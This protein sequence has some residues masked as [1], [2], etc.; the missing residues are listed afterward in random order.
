[1]RAFRPAGKPGRSDATPSPIEWVTSPDE[2]ARRLLQIA[3]MIGTRQHRQGY[4]THCLIPVVWLYYLVTIITC[5]CRGFFLPV[6]YQVVPPTP[7]YCVA[8]TNLVVTRITSTSGV[9][10]IVDFAPKFSHFD[11]LFRP[12]QLFRIIRKISGD[13]CIRI[14]IRPTFGYN[15]TDGYRTRGSHHIRY[16]GPTV[17]WRVTTT[18]SVQHIID[19]TPFLLTG[20]ASEPEVIVFGQ[21]ESFASSLRTVARE[22]QEKTA[23]YWRGWSLNLSLP[24]F[25]GE[26][27]A[28]LVGSGGRGGG[29]SGSGAA[30]PSGGAAVGRIDEESRGGEAAASAASGKSGAGPKSGSGGSPSSVSPVVGT[31]A[32]VASSDRVGSSQTAA[33]VL[34][35]HIRNSNSRTQKRSH[36]Y[37]TLLI[38]AAIHLIQQQCEENGGLLSCLTMGHPLTKAQHVFRDDMPGRTTSSS[39][40]SAS[41]GAGSSSTSKI[42]A[43]NI[44]WRDAR[45][46]RLLDLQKKNAL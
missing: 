36:F 27:G 33:D 17:T 34:E 2:T 44:L 38:R 42:L 41:P 28:S 45:V 10:E 3:L 6:A 8:L 16:C 13:P 9:M 29:S 26:V 5:G 43:S 32:A 22:F 46:C 4:R 40:N 11:R 24:V 7:P 39:T 18:I 37:Q 1:M 15:S 30:R 23:M 20:N 14:R 19:E 25:V 35:D 12:F 31:G 21:D